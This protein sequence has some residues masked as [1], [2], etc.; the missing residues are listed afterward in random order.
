MAVRPSVPAREIHVTSNVGWT[1]VGASTVL[2]LGPGDPTRDGWRAYLEGNDQRLTSRREI[3]GV[4]VFPI[5]TA[6]PN[7]GQRAELR[8]QLERHAWKGPVAIVV[9]SPLALTIARIVALI[10]QEMKPFGPEAVD[11]AIRHARLDAHRD[12]ALSAGR[13]LWRALSQ[14]KVSFDLGARRR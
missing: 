1:W 13:E 3:S 9:S 10:G 6:A 5:G 14:G 8:A 4:L 7:A 2:A 11:D 12:D